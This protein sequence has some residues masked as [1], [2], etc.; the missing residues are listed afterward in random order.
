MYGVVGI[1]RMSKHVT[2]AYVVLALCM[3]QD[4]FEKGS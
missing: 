3:V 1:F 2:K 4:G